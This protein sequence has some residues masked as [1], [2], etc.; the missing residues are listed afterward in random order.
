MKKTNL[1]WAAAAALIL[2]GCSSAN[3]NSQAANDADVSETS[4]SETSVSNE[5]ASEDAQESGEKV[6][7]K[8]TSCNSGTVTG[9]K[10][11]GM[12][13]PPKMNGEEP[14]AGD[15]PD[16][17]SG[18]NPPEMNGDK[19]EG[20]PPTGGNKPDSAPQ[21]GEEVSYSVGD[22]DVSGISEGDMVKIVLDES[23]NVISITK[24]EIPQPGQPGGGFG[25]NG[26]DNGTAAN[27]ADDN[28]VLSNMS[29][30]SENDDE[31]ALRADGVTVSLTDCTITK[32]GSS[33]NTKNG[34]FYGM[35]AALLAENG[36]QVTVIGGE[37]STSATNGNGIFSYGSGTV[38][39]VS[40]TKIR[41]AERNSGGI[42]TTGGGTM[43]AEDLDVQTEGNSSAAI[44][45]DRGG[46]TVNVKG[47]T[48]VTN[49]TGSP[50]IYST[51]DISVSD[52]V[53]TANNSEGIVVEGKNSVKLTDCTL[54]GKMQGTYNDDSEN[55][56]CIMIYQSM[57][58]DADVGE[59]YFEA[60]GGEITSL[61]GDMFYVTNT[62]CEIKLSGVKLNMS[63]GVFLRVVGNSSSRSWGKSGEN[64]GDVK[65]S[66]TDQTVEGDIVVDEISTLDLDMSGS[67]LTGAINADNSGGNIS[68]SLD[69][70][71]TWNL[72]SDCYISSFDGDI[73]NINAGEFHL[74]VNGEMV[75]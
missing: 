17:G 60:N 4:I 62:S 9:N 66:L 19:P 13:E 61:A 65:M 6:M 24:E 48:Y 44:R 67:V 50:A 5:S 1:I 23:G 27:N 3:D 39:N 57:S 7:I 21:M 42:Q 11:G 64:G 10:M 69:E 22:M 35:N 52:A 40:G 31:N 20:E 2:A 53:L 36:A 68:V 49:G 18:D 54:S 34:D 28:A 75:V 38:V 12:G 32:T 70:N 72:T 30:S 15:K 33:S 63:D 43:N 29:Y 25:A 46:G 45:S 26:T 55:I 14:P 56:Q 37:V 8:V 41:T 51:A 73:S 71:S 58:G 74:Y 16:N 47:G 59:A